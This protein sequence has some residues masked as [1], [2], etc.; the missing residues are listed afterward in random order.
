MPEY[1]V[2]D[3]ERKR[4]SV[5]AL[6]DGAYVPVPGEGDRARS[7]VLPGFEL[8]VPALFVGLA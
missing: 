4:V 2:V 3:P 8:D 1:W 7:L 5:F 6:R